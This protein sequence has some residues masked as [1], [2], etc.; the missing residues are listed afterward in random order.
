M[1]ERKDCGCR[2]GSFSVNRF[3][4]PHEQAEIAYQKGLRMQEL[5]QKL[6]EMGA[7]ESRLAAASPDVVLALIEQVEKMRE[8]L[9]RI[10]TADAYEEAPI[11]C[12]WAR[13][14]LSSL[15]QVTNDEGGVG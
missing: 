1:S 4:C 2:G 5:N 10:S 8:V 3:I 14:C 12:D 13:D 15:S 7:L 9:E 11:E 6:K